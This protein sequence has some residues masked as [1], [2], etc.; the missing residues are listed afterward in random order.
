MLTFLLRLRITCFTKVVLPEPQGPQIKVLIK[1]SKLLLNSIFS[2]SL[3]AKQTY[4]QISLGKRESP[5]AELYEHSL[6]DDS[7][8]EEELKPDRFERFLNYVG[9][10]LPKN[11]WVRAALAIGSGIAASKHTNPAITLL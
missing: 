3:L 11:K 8:L 9:S 10:K 6:L 7:S 4:R 2:L 5:T 1:F